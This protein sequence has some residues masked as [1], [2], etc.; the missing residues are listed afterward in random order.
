MPDPEKKFNDFPVS[1]FVVVKFIYDQG[2]KNSIEKQYVGQVIELQQSEISIKFMR[3]SSKT[4]DTF[5]FPMVDDIQDVSS[6]QILD[7]VEPIKISKGR[8]LFPKTIRA[9][10]CS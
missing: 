4:E 3:K 9:Y 1:S 6:D 5:V 10:N 2:T 8:H 7:Q